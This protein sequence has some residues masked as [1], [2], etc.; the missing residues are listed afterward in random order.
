MLLYYEGF[1]ANKLE[2]LQEME[3]FLEDIYLNQKASRR[4]WNQYRP[5]TIKETE[6]M[7]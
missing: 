4:N 2:N 6:I 3:K 5:T 1:Y 7:D